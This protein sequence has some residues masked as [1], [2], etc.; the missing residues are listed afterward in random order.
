MRSSTEDFGGV[1]TVR[2]AEDDSFGKYTFHPLTLAFPRLAWVKI[3]EMAEDMRRSGG[4]PPVLK[5]GE[6]IL[7]D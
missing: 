6:V 2:S 1:G 7:D 5:H 4:A 3:E